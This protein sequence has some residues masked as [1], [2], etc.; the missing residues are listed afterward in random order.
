MALHHFCSSATD[1]RNRELVRH[2]APPFPLACYWHDGETVNRV[3]WHWHEELETVLVKAG[4]AVVFVEG[5]RRE[6]GPGEGCFIAA[7]ALHNARREGEEPMDLHSM[8]FHP[9]LVGGG[10]ESVF[11]QNYLQ[12]LLAEG[13]NRCVWLSEGVPWE[14][15]ALEAMEA[16]WR[17]CG[18]EPPGFE[19]LAREG[20]SRLV[21]LLSAHRPAVKKGPSEKALRDGE[22]I[23]AMLRFVQEHY[24]EELTAAR[25][26]G[27]AA[28]SESECL[29]CFRSMVGTTP[30]QYVKQFRVQRAAELLES[31]EEKVA[32][33][34]AACGFQEMSYFA[35]T[36][37]ALK[38]KP[39]SRYRAERRAASG[40][41]PEN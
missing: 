26:A 40:D 17:A 30:M 2:G 6:L 21:F 24:H 15:E 5:E 9:R 19:F 36:F 37:R 25:I 28:L 34:G 31:T 41:A 22:R 1:G 14:R 23:K 7:G 29:R 20:L 3:P 11:W 27:S 39:P 16:A 8:V 38:G 12:P 33:V 18:E 32:A 35:R 10:V 13:A 4:R